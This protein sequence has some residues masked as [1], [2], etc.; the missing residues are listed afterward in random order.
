[1]GTLC[2]ESK[3]MTLALLRIARRMQDSSSIFAERTSA[4]TASSPELL[5][6]AGLLGSLVVLLGLL[7]MY[8]ISINTKPKSKYARKA[9]SDMD[10]SR[11]RNGGAASATLNGAK[12]GAAKNRAKAANHDGRTA[13]DAAE[14]SLKAVDET[15]EATS[16]PGTVALKIQWSSDKPTRAMQGATRGAALL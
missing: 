16:P 9:A 8:S 5:L 15:K 13:A 6:S 4:S 3:Q 14:V 10:S 1:M 12:N 7:A 2:D 11:T